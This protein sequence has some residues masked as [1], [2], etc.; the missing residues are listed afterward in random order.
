MSTLRMG[1]QIGSNGGA[2]Y[3]LELLHGEMVGEAVRLGEGGQE[4]RT[5]YLRPSWVSVAES[6]S[7]PC[8]DWNLT[9]VR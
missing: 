6:K 1:A 2:R 3:S 8:P 5:P 7:L 9:L 4:E